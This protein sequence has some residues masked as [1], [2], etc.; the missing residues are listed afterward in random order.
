MIRLGLALMLFVAADAHSATLHLNLRV[1]EET[2]THARVFIAG[3]FQ[4]WDPASADFELTKTGDRHYEID[5]DLPEGLVKFKFTRGGWASVEKS[6]HGGDIRNRVLTLTKD[7]N[8]DLR[9]ARWADI[10]EPRTLTGDVT[11]HTIEGFL[12]GRR[13]WVYLP[14]GYSDSKAG[15]P[16]LVMLDGQNLFDESTSFAGEWEVDETCER[17]IGSQKIRPLIVVAVDNGGTDRQSEYTPWTDSKYGGGGGRDHLQVL[18]S[19]LLPWVRANYRVLDGPT[20]WGFAG[21]S[22]GGLMSVYVA[23]QYPELFG[24]VGALSPSVYWHKS[25]LVDLAARVDPPTQSRL[26]IDMGS[27]ESADAVGQLD[28]LCA[29]LVERGWKSGDQLKC[30]ED[31]GASHNE[32]AWARRFPKVLQFLFP[33]S[34]EVGRRRD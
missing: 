11:E 1:P 29:A 17:L 14:P 26:W 16:V 5:L 8:L 24:R 23:L 6:P 13:V 19:Q 9:V 10:G 32:A 18:F 15:Y 2:P 28:S 27:A 3:D 33:L 30:V 20:N 21:S 34:D 22:L 12:D 4:G 25:A 7:R 31:K